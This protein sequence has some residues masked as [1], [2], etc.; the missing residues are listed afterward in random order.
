MA[1]EVQRRAEDM[2][3]ARWPDQFAYHGVADFVL[4]EGREYEPSRLSLSSFAPGRPGRCF[5][6]AAQ[7]ASENPSLVYVQG[8]AWNVVPCEHAWCVDEQGRVVDPTWGHQTDW[9]QLRYFGVA[10]RIEFVRRMQKGGCYSVFEGE[11]HAVLKTTTPRE[12]WALKPPATFGLIFMRDP[13]NSRTSRQC[14]F[15]QVTDS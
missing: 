8:F 4:R 11:D 1:I 2:P 3:G 15:G 12:W 10:L 14:R 6:N 13:H 5:E 7:I 9:H